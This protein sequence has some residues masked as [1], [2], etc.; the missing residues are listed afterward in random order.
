[1]LGPLRLSVVRIVILEDQREEA[2]RS[3]AELQRGVGPSNAP[4]AA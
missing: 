2:Q 4:P 3:N 1:M